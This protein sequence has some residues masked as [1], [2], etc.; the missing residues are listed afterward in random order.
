MKV[1]EDKGALEIF[2]CKL[3]STGKAFEAMAS[4]QHNSNTSPPFYRTVTD[5]M[6]YVLAKDEEEFGIF[7]SLIALSWT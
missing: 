3:R 1:H 5:C 2:D 6:L 7:R 4:I